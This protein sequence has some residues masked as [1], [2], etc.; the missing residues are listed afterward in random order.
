MTRTTDEE[1]DQDQ[2]QEEL[3]TEQPKDGGLTP[4]QEFVLVQLSSLD[5]RNDE[6][7][8][9]VLRNYPELRSQILE[10]AMANFGN[11]MVERAIARVDG[12]FVDEQIEQMEQQSSDE[13]F[14]DK[15]IAEEEAVQTTT[16]L[17]AETT[18][19]PEPEQAAQVEAVDTMTKEDD[20]MLAAALEAAPDAREQVVEKATE[21]LGAE[22]VESA[23]EIQ[24]EEQ[25][26]MP[27]EIL[28]AE[29]VPEQEVVAQVA[30]APKADVTSEAWYQHAKEYN[31]FHSSMVDRFVEIAG[32]ELR[33]PDGSVDPTVIVAW[34][35]TN[36]V[37][38]DGRV[39]PL[40]LAAAREGAKKVSV[41]EA[42]IEVQE[43]QPAAE[44]V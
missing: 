10:Y 4:E 13:A 36:G 33:L 22:T 8:A 32:T 44:A 41:A 38:P 20:V 17:S 24:A 34:Q 30:E 11:T 29:V 42:V 15:Q 21:Q 14:I 23:I 2:K 35:E 7:L 12:S 19:E 6:L 26:Q 16:E 5:S 39:G 28:A 27:A 1:L 9:D 37:K 43:D 40:T 25:A 18:T 3:V 31:F